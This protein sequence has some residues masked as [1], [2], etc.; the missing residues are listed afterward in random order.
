ML[1]PRPSADHG[2]PPVHV[3]NLARLTCTQELPIFR[4]RSATLAARLLHGARNFLALA[5]HHSLLREPPRPMN[6]LTQ[7]SR[8]A[9]VKGALVLA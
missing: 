4:P 2:S 3:V 5:A 1:E 7:R 9:I 8:T 6:G